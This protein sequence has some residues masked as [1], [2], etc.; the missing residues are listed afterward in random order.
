MISLSTVARMCEVLWQI[1]ATLTSSR[2]WRG[3]GVTQLY[4]GSKQFSS[5][6][7]LDRLGHRG[8]RRDDSAELLFQSF[9]QEALLGSFGFSRDV[10]LFDVV[11]P[12]FP[13]PTMASPTL[14][15]AL[16]DG[17]GEDV[18]ACDMPEPCKFLSLKRGAK[19]TMSIL[20]GQF[21]NLCHVKYAVH[22]N[23]GGG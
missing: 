10:S 14:Q 17:F 12:A 3:C 11:H 22:A 18:L 7:S 16:K 2:L 6:Q 23:V 13:L 15:G 19:L 1:T 9:P 5:F 4:G 8:D 20:F 21:Q